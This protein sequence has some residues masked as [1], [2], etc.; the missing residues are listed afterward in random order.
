[1]AGSTMAEGG[2]H[3]EGEPAAEAPD[4]CWLQ[5]LRLDPEEKTDASGLPGDS[6]KAQR[7]GW[8]WVSG[9]LHLQRS[10]SPEVR[11]AGRGSATPPHPGC[12]TS[13]KQP[14]LSELLFQGG[15]T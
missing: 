2:S 4:P 8:A 6:C 10:K 13:G 14:H 11:R 3:G 7:A 12:V 15:Y 1:M 9:K 5:T